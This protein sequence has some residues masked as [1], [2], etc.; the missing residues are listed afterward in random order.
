ML[1]FYTLSQITI[2]FFLV[3]LSAFFSSS[4]TALTSLSEPLL[5]KK[6]SEG[7]QRAAKTQKLLKKKRNRNKRNTFRK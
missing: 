7:D 5:Q 6:I 4:E 2:I 1:D 3:M